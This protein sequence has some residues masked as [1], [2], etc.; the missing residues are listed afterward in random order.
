MTLKLSQMMNVGI[1][2]F[3]GPA[4]FI[5]ANGLFGFPLFFSWLISLC[6]GFDDWSTSLLTAKCLDFISSRSAGCVLCE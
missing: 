4:Q 6:L 3:S 2:D 5:R 1:L